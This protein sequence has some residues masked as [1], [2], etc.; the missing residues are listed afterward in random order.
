[1]RACQTLT[2]NTPCPVTATIVTKNGSGILYRS[3]DYGATWQVVSGSTATAFWIGAACD[4]T[5][6]LFLAANN[7]YIYKSG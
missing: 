3:R 4:Y 2:P 7:V 6:S 1:M 5:G